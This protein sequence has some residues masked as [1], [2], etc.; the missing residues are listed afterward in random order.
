MDPTVGARL[1]ILLGNYHTVV[2]EIL[3][4]PLL[5]VTRKQ[6]QTKIRHIVQL[7]LAKG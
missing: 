2:T 6:E 1:N 3:I 7:D 4:F 5:S